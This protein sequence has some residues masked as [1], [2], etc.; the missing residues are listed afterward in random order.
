MHMGERPRCLLDSCF[1]MI[2]R[3]YS[4]RVTPECAMTL[5]RHARARSSLR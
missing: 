2:Q 3:F 5:I 1:R 4:V